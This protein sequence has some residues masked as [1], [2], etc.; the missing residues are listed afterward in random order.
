MIV[1]VKASVLFRLLILF[2]TRSGD[3]MLYG[4]I[5]KSPMKIYTPMLLDGLV[6]VL[7]FMVFLNSGFVVRAING[8]NG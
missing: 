2:L 6:R 3:A 1:S 8:N 4:L 7:I 5:I